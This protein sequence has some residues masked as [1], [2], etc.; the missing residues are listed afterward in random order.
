MIF[1][2]IMMYF[3]YTVFI[4][5]CLCAFIVLLLIVLLNMEQWK[6][7]NPKQKFTLFPK[8]VWNMRGKNYYNG[9]VWLCWYWD[10]GYDSNTKYFRLTYESEAPMRHHRFTRTYT[11]S[12]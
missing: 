11:N 9:L 6:M 8:R 4:V 10:C 12:W 5:L 2:I 3:G 7:F 1:D